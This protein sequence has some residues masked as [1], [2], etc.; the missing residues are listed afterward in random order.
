M[1]RRQKYWDFLRY[2]IT[3]PFT[4]VFIDVPEFTFVKTLDIIMDTLAVE[5][6]G[7]ADVVMFFL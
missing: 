7:F 6:F 3:N 5:I 2:V 1:E 4:F